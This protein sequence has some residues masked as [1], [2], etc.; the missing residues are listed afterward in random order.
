MV[1]VEYDH[2]CDS[3]HLT[4]GSAKNVTGHSTRLARE[5]LA[6]RRTLS[7]GDVQ[8]ILYG[9][10]EPLNSIRQALDDIHIRVSNRFDD[11]KQ[12]DEEINA[13]NKVF[14]ETWKLSVRPLPCL[15]KQSAEMVEWKLP[16]VDIQESNP[17]TVEEELARLKVLRT[18]FILECDARDEFDRITDIACERFKVPL[19]MVTFIDFGEQWYLSVTGTDIKHTT[20]KHAFCAHTII[21]KQ[22]M[23]IV[24]DASKDFRFQHSPFV[25]GFP[26]IRF[27]AGVALVSPEGYKLGTFCVLSTLPRPDG[28]SLEDQNLM[29]EMADI[30]MKT[31]VSAKTRHLLKQQH[32]AKLR[33]MG[34]TLIEVPVHLTE[35]KTCLSAWDIREAVECDLPSTISTNETS[36]DHSTSQY[37]E[38]TMLSSVLSSPSSS[39]ESRWSDQSNHCVLP[40]CPRQAQ[41]DSESNEA[42][43]SGTRTSSFHPPRAPRRTPEF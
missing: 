41:F 11:K 33:R 34:R 14:F 12:K 27:Y 31:M 22:K 24:P 10:D 8:T 26:H 28:M 39:S 7:F 36:D 16:L 30:V 1:S 2:G 19:S 9:D 13:L 25:A 40:R 37:S 42:S 32:E 6:S 35:R 38:I 17:Q 3:P 29:M 21:S 43:L 5:G 18:Y 4:N 15:S 20:R 23:L